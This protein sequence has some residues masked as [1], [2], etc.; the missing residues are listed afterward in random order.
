MAPVALTTFHP[1]PYTSHLY[2]ILMS[3][4]EAESNRLQALFRAGRYA[5]LEASAQAFLARQPQAGGI[6]YLLGQT[7]LAQGRLQVARQALERASTLLSAQ[8]PDR[9]VMRAGQK[10]LGARQG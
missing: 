3:P 5:E 4:F 7:Y 1:V 6:W 2:G 10:A 8:A 9:T